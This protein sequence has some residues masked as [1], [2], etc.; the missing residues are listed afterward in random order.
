MD[1]EFSC[2]ELAQ[3]EL[4]VL[5]TIIR[6]Q[7]RARVYRH[8]LFMRHAL[9]VHRE[10]SATLRR[11]KKEKRTVTSIQK[12]AKRL[13]PK[14]L[15]RLLLAAGLS[16]MDETCARR[17]DTMPLTLILLGIYA[18]LRATLNLDELKQLHRVKDLSFARP[19]DLSLD[20]NRTTGPRS[21]RFLRSM[22]TSQNTTIGDI[23]SHFNGMDAVT[24]KRKKRPRQ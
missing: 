24:N 2:V 21:C 15:K 9:R 14:G 16:A 8:H 4:H 19:L 10:I 5:S 13:S 6:S 18:R 20:S 23:M 3:H 1:R 7:S 22:E 17:I 12:K 11:Y